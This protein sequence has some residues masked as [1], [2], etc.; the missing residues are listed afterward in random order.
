MNPDKLIAHRGWQQRYPE[1]TLIAI[2]QAI[3]AGAVNIEIDI[4]LNAEH[5]A[6]LCHDDNLLRLSGVCLD[7]FNC[8]R[9]DL[10]E[11][12]AHEPGRLGEQF[13]G[14]PFCSLQQCLQLISLH[15][16]VTLFIE[17]KQESI[18]RFGYQCVLD[19]LIPLCWPHRQQCV[20]ISFDFIILELAAATGWLRTGPILEQWQQLDKINAGQAAIEIIFCDYTELP[21]GLNARNLDYPL[22]VYEVD[23]IVLAEQLLECGIRLIET[24][25]IGELIA[26]S[27]Q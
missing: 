2:E 10:S 14:N 27:N 13:I 4:Q 21:T 25:R 16:L 20:F 9:Q 8:T 19:S 15:P 26:Q 3:A 22:A 18:D 23:N 24:F 6:I 11:L 7:I 1:N 5:I 17:I 12:S